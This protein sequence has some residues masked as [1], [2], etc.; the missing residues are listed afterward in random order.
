MPEEP[1]PSPVGDK[2][3]LEE[4]SAETGPRPRKSVSGVYLTYPQA[5]RDLQE[6]RNEILLSDRYRK[7]QEKSE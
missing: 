5:K 6:I 4:P 7:P 2:R 1:D 3:P